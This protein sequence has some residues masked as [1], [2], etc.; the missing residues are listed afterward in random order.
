MAP[1]FRDLDQTVRRAQGFS[2]ILL[3]PAFAGIGFLLGILIGIPDRFLLLFALGCGVVGWV[4]VYFTS[5]W[6]TN[7][8]ATAISRIV[9]PTGRST[10]YA[11]TFSL[12]DSLVA[13]GNFDEA[14]ELYEAHLARHHDDVEAHSRTAEL[15]LRA[16]N[17][18]RAAAVFVALR[19]IPGVPQ[20][21]EL[22]ATQRLVD[23]YLESLG[24]Q[25][26]ALVELRRLVERFP[27]TVEAHHARE[28]IARL[29]VLE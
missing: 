18:A 23:I 19:R 17:A 22:Y 27:A 15:Y 8:T 25:G 14:L 9:L 3:A 2:L 11:H 26:R 29:K 12:Q 20:S 10:P 21:R 6:I 13:Q 7:T 4:F 24:D 16:G 5:Q 1:R 28:A